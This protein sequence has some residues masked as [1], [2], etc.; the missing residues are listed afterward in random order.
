MVI[1]MNWKTL[2][3]EKDNGTYALSGMMHQCASYFNVDEHS[4]CVKYIVETYLE[5]IS[6]C[7]FLEWIRGFNP[8][9]KVIVMDKE[10][11]QENF[12]DLWSYSNDLEVIQ[13]LFMYLYNQEM[14]IDKKAN[15][16][17]STT[18]NLSLQDRVELNY[19]GIAMEYERLCVLREKE[20]IGWNDIDT[21]I[22]CV[23][24]YGYDMTKD[25]EYRTDDVDETADN[26]IERIQQIF[27]L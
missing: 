21:F 4:E 23:D 9:E 17:F 22:E 18:F 25:Y 8:S 15:V 2:A 27:P 11:L 16:L 19:I 7:T 20:I 26:V 5:C 12:S 14:W 13:D 6:N 24:Y 10:F 3:K 1:K